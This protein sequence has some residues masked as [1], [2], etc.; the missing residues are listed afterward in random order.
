ML[1]DYIK[2]HSLENIEAIAFNQTSVNC[3][4][5]FFGDTDAPISSFWDLMV[6]RDGYNKWQ[7]CKNI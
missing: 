2:E 7:K 6:E 3:F 5:V 4:S 1:S